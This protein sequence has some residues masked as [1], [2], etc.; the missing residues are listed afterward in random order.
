MIWSL[1]LLKE[2]FSDLR[3]DS[4]LNGTG[5]PASKQ[6]KR[7]S[8]PRPSILQVLTCLG[9]LAGVL[10]VWVPR[11]RSVQI[12]TI[13]AV[14]S[15]ALWVS[16]VRLEGHLD[17]GSSVEAAFSP[18][19]GTL[20][21]AGN[22]SVVLF[23]LK[24][25][26]IK[27]VLRPHVEDITD[28]N[29]LSANFLDDFNIFIRARGKIRGEGRE[30]NV[31]ESPELIFQWSTVQDALEGTVKPLT[32]GGQCG[33][34]VYFPRMS[35]LIRFSGGGFDLW[36]AKQNRGG[37]LMVE[38]LT[39]RPDV[40]TISPDGQWL[41]AARFAG[42]SQSNVVVIRL[43]DQ[44][45]ITALKGHEAMPFCISYSPDGSQVAT[46]GQDRTIRIW[47]TSDW[48]L[49]EIL[50]GHTGTVNWVAFSPDGRQ[51]VSGGDDK[52]VRIWL[53]SGGEP[54]QTISDHNAP[55]HTVAFSP[56]GNYLVSSSERDVRV[57]NKV[58]VDR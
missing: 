44:Q 29:V 51:I 26:E 11:G 21:V 49:Q 6:T 10:A 12:E 47:R 13:D 56:D 39:R 43:K 4:L 55:V 58:M 28:L 19:G 1:N 53:S 24:R 20:A 2:K 17:L 48:S 15:R 45:M 33:P 27:R 23:D 52:S 31:R 50:K 35:Y 36:S 40:F 41:L 34:W 5:D 54:L 16:M 3:V 18:D 7:Y 30:G 37:K 38:T 46:A 22:G 42:S 32:R 8:R 9:V 14:G 57:Y 25:Q